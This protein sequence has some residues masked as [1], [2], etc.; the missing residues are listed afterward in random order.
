MECAVELALDGKL[1]AFPGVLP[2]ALATR[3][4]GRRLIIPRECADEAALAGD[5][6]V[7]PADNL[8][9]VVAHLLGQES[10]VPHRLGSRAKAEGLI[11]DLA[12]VRGQHQARR[13]LEVAAA[14]GHNLLFAGPP[15][16]RQDHARQPVARHFTAAERR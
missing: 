8:W 3:R 7:L 6:A 15:C 10:I 12:E 4:T 14:G 16:H 5:L 13:A 11:D 1:R 2:F 9:Q